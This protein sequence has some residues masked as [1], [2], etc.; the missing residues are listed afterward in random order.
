V[1]KND[2]ASL[3]SLMGELKNDIQSTMKTLGTSIDSDLDKAKT[4]I[5]SKI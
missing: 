2:V 4:E 5:I 1:G 3:D